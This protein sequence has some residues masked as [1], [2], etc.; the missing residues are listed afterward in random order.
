MGL[1]SRAKKE[2]CLYLISYSS[3]T[4]DPLQAVVCFHPEQMILKRLHVHHVLSCVTDCLLSGAEW[5]F[6]IHSCSKYGPFCVVG[7]L[8]T[9]GP[10]Y[11]KNLEWAF[12]NVHSNLT[13]QRHPSAYSL[14]SFSWAGY[15]PP[16]FSRIATS[17]TWLMSTW[18]VA[19]L[20]WVVYKFKL[21]SRFPRLSMLKI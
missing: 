11:V 13:L 9:A 16:L 12:K 2:R 17:C 10:C 5:S 15:R 1:G 7:E 21:H 20:N 14:N 6:L 18:S 3:P 4:Q 19:N 8:L